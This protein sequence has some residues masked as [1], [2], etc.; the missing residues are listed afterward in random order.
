ML[1]IVGYV[2]VGTCRVSPDHN[3]LAYTVD[4]TGS[5]Y[6]RLQVND[7][8]TGLIIPKLQ[9]GVV[10]LAWAEEGRMLF[11]TQ[12]DEN[13]RP[14]RQN[15]SFLAFSLRIAFSWHSLFSAAALTFGRVFCTKVG[16]SDAEDV[17]V[18]VEDDPNYCVDITSTKDGKF[19]TV[20]S[21]SRTS[22]EE[23]TY[24]FQFFFFSFSIFL[25]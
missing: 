9:E 11:Y 23:G 1:I 5:E 12:A 6:F 21:N 13:Q 7:L 15:S 14:C 17:L 20:N 18:F 8:R 19:I 16:C 25:L 2:H 24:L 22:S 10:S 3:F 4:V